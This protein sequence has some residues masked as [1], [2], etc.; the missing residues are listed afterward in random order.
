MRTTLRF[1]TLLTVLGTSALRADPP[2]PYSTTFGLS[3]PILATG[4]LVT[5]TYYGWEET[6]YYGHTVW[7]FTPEQYQQNLANQ[8]YWWVPGGQCSTISGI[9]LFEKPLGQSANPYLT[10]P[11]AST[12]SWTPGTEIIFALMVNQGDGYNWFFSGDPARNSSDGYAHLAYFSPAQ[13]PNGV[14]GN[15][16]EGLVPHTEG[17][18]LF[19]FEDVTYSPSDWD[20]NNSIFAV[21]GETIGTPQEVTPEPATLTLL[22]TGVAGLGSLA[23][24]RRQRAASSE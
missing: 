16:G 15:E 10:T 4:N 14:P 8:C 21:D 9:D 13:F 6:T 1:L 24:R 2:K 22:A 17:K 11:L 7:A 19:G 18:I 3:S 20:F 23:R 5:A 12:F